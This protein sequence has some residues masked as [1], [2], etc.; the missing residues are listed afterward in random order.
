MHSMRGGFIFLNQQDLDLELF[1]RLGILHARAFLFPALNVARI[2]GMDSFLDLV[3][4]GVAV[5]ILF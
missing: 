2:H 5:W 4:L 1:M 3:P